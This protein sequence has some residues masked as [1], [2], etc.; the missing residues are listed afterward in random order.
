L[1]ERGAEKTATGGGEDAAVATEETRVVTKGDRQ[2]GI[3]LLNLLVS[4]FGRSCSCVS[5]ARFPPMESWD[6]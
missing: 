2:R 1:L 6:G 4:M 5:E 3:L